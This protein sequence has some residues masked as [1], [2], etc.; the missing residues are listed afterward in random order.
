MQFRNIRQCF[1]V[2]GFEANI[3]SSSKGIGRRYSKG[4]GIEGA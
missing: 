2:V 1:K 3:H 4:E